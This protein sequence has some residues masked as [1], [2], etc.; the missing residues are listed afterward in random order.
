[1]FAEVRLLDL[2]PQPSRRLLSPG[3][4]GGS[5]GNN[6]VEAL[7]TSSRLRRNNAALCV[8]RYNSSG[9]GGSHGA[10]LADVQSEVA[11]CA[12]V[13][14]HLR[15]HYGCAM[16][17]LVGYSFGALVAHAAAA[18][19]A[20]VVGYALVSFPYLMAPSRF[21]VRRPAPH[22]LTPHTSPT[23]APPPPVVFP[24]FQV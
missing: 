10:C 23:R 4:A 15:H 16:L 12:A 22:V 9:V 2:L 20:G 8:C 19:T 17:V 14:S 7:W 6:V 21:P 11:D 18:S 3:G 1:V 5:K 24:R 13:C